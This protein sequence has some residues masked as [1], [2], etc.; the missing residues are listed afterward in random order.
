MGLRCDRGMATPSLTWCPM[1]VLEGSI[2]SLSLLSF[3]QRSLPMSPGSLSTPRSLV[4]SR[5]SPQPPISWGC[6]FPFFLLALR[7]SVIFPHPIPDQVPFYPP[8]PSQPVHIPSLQSKIRPCI[9]EKDY[10]GHYKECVQWDEK[11]RKKK[12]KNNVFYLPLR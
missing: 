10:W 4:H 9:T 6:L 3:H 8:L 1:F 11:K 5:G 12:K 2:N 7:A